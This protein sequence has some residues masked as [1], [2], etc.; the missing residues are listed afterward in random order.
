MKKLPLILALACLLSSS[1]FAQCNIYDPKTVVEQRSDGIYCNGVKGK[2]F[3]ASDFDCSE[4]EI[5][6]D[7]Y[8][9]HKGKKITGLSPVGLFCGD[10]IKG[11]DKAKRRQEQR[12]NEY[13]NKSH[14]NPKK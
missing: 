8:Y 12:E 1:A 10:K 5:K 3:K 14:N 13:Q 7:D 2:K 11:Y 9:Y 6:D 4:Y